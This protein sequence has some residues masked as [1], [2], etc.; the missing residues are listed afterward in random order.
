MMWKPTTDSIRKLV[1]LLRYAE[2]EIGLLCPSCNKN[3]RLSRLSES[4]MRCGS[5]GFTG[6]R[7]LFTSHAGSVFQSRID[8]V[9]K[10]TEEDSSGDSGYRDVR[11]RLYPETVDK[12]EALKELLGSNNTADAVSGALHL[13]LE[14]VKA[15]VQG[16]KVVLVSNDGTREEMLI[17]WGTMVG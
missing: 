5:C 7:D 1:A 13:A 16:K 8:E 4:I 6:S 9:F 2:S 17:T 11:M 15:R 12:A 14:I 10:E 3:S